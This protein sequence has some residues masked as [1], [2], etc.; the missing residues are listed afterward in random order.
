[1]R[2]T[3]L[4]A[5]RRTCRCGAGGYVYVG[6]RIWALLGLHNSTILPLNWGRVSKPVGC[7]WMQDVVA[8]GADPVAQ[9]VR[10]ASCGGALHLRNQLGAPERHA[11]ASPTPSD[12]CHSLDTS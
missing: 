1:M 12:A 9:A 11:Q 6:N 4:L 2:E 10:Q 7:S 5:I 3:E 8:V